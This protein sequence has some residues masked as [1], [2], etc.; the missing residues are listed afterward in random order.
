MTV[1]SSILDPIPPLSTPQSTATAC[2]WVCVHSR[3]VG[4]QRHGASETTAIV[5]PSSPKE[6]VLSVSVPLATSDVRLTP[7]S[8]STSIPEG[9]Y[10]LVA[11]T[12]GTVDLLVGLA[13]SVVWV[14]C[15]IPGCPELRC[16]R[17]ARD[18]R[19]PRIICTRGSST[20]PDVVVRPSHLKSSRISP[21]GMHLL[22]YGWLD[23]LRPVT[24]VSVVDALRC[25]SLE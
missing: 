14:R 13:S 10:L 18:D 12:L 7:I 22:L 24:C 5:R 17:G 21:N 15:V 4:A 20:A 6:V 9:I 16:Q 8:T 2:V 23:R 25:V 19:S 3:G 11:G 1:I